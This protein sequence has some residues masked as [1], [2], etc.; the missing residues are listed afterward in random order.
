MKVVHGRLVCRQEST[1]LELHG[2]DR[3][4]R[5]T[6]FH[7]TYPSIYLFVFYIPIHQVRI[8]ETGVTRVI[9]GIRGI[10]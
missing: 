8:S 7:L 6:G 10:S 1:E 4:T 5:C 3:I 9:C 2:L